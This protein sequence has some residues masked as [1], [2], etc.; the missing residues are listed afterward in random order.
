MSLVICVCVRSGLIGQCEV[1][2]FGSARFCPLQCILLMRVGKQNQYR[3]KWMA[4]T[5]YIKGQNGKL[6]GGLHEYE[7]GDGRKF[8]SGHTTTGSKNTQRLMLTS[9]EEYAL[10]TNKSGHSYH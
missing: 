1:L 9:S 2:H 7:V 3:K 6:N 5:Y 10:G 8:V 4:T